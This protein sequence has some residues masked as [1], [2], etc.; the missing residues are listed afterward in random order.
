M[1]GGAL[2]TLIVAPLMV[3]SSASGAPSKSLLAHAKASSVQSAS[4]AVVAPIPRAA[5]L[6]QAQLVQARIVEHG[7]AVAKAK[8]RAA[9]RAALRRARAEAAQARAQALASARVAQQRAAEKAATTTTTTKPRVHHRVV[10]QPKVVITAANSKAGYATYYYWHRGECA[11]P[12][13]PHGTKVV[14]HNSA[15]GARATCV[16]TDTQGNI[17]GRII[18]LDSSVFAK[19]APLGEGVVAVTISW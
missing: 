17:P 3:V 5:I 19:L 14:I 7:Q 12:W 8:V 10:V 18:D 13:L 9:A 11:S 1:A 6:H 16:V 2:A 15:T 4:S